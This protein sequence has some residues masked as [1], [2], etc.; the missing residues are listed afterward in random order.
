MAHLKDN[1]ASPVAPTLAP[2][3]QPESPDPTVTRP[4]FPPYSAVTAHKGHWIG[5]APG[6]GLAFCQRAVEAGMTGSSLLSPPAPRTQERP[7]LAR[8]RAGRTIG[9]F[10]N[11]PSRVFLLRRI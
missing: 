3:V 5:Q 9:T 4:P 10:L 2:Q 8:V 6:W 1:L 7:V 11:Q